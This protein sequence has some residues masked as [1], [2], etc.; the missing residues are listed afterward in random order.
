VSKKCRCCLAIPIFLTLSAYCNGQPTPNGLLHGLLVSRQN[1][2]SC[3]MTLWLQVDS[4]ALRNTATYSVEAMGPSLRFEC[5]EPRSLVVASNGQYFRFF[6]SPGEDLEIRSLDAASGT[7]GSLAFD[8]R[9]LGLSDTCSLAVSL[10]DTIWV[11]EGMRTTID[12]PISELGASVWEVTSVRGVSS[13]KYWIDANSFRLFKKTVEVGDIAIEIVSTYADGNKGVIPN[14][15]V[16]RRSDATGQSEKIFTITNLRYGEVDMN[17][18][19]LSAFDLPIG[20]KAVDYQL[21]KAVG[22]WD[23]SSFAPEVSQVGNLTGGRSSAFRNGA[24]LLLVGVV[25]YWVVRWRTSGAK[26]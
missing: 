20:T 19:D 4:G 21:K 18:F 15:V 17:R 12:G 9:L 3:S 26:L 16:V 8:P 1:V 2:K 10:E 5:S 23:G 7:T 11:G 22:F 24:M 25:L 6:R 13:A 14:A